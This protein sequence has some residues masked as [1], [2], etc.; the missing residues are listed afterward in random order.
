MLDHFALEGSGQYLVWQYID[1]VDLQELVRQY[2]TLP[3][4]LII[5]WLQAA[6]FPWP[7]PIE[8]KPFVKSAIYFSK[9]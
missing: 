8:L 7:W 2:G 9:A 5:T 4:D 3:S 6:C 1:G